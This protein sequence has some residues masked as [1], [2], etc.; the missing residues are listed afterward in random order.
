VRVLL[1]EEEVEVE[2]LKKETAAVRASA[3]NNPA[4]VLLL[5]Q[6]YERLGMYDD[7]LAS[8]QAAL[9]LRPGDEGVQAAVRRLSS[10]G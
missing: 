1:P 8:Y 7:A 2:A 5:A 9:K 6:I 10:R 4:P 3:P